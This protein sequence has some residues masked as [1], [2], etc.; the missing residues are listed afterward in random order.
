MIVSLRTVCRCLRFVCQSPIIDKTLKVR[1]LYFQNV[2]ALLLYLVVVIAVVVAVVAVVVYVTSFFVGHCSTFSLSSKSSS[3]KMKLFS[4]LL[5]FWTHVKFG[6]KLRL[7]L[8]IY[9]A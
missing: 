6:F 8:I 7:F 4:G 3:R 9:G 2:N 1:S 5:P